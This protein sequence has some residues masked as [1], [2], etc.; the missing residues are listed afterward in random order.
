MICTH[1]T[2]VKRVRADPAD[3]QVSTLCGS[4]GAWW[5]DLLIDDEID[6]SFW[7]AELRQEHAALMERL[8]EIDMEMQWFFDSSVDSNADD[9]HD[10]EGQTIAFERALLAADG[11]RTREHLEEVEAALERLAQGDYGLCEVCH[12]AIDPDRLEVRPTARTCVAHA[13]QRR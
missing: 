7:E 5:W 8:E 2:P 12:E 9:E 13:P 6:E 10:P 11:S 4:V 3:G 1:A